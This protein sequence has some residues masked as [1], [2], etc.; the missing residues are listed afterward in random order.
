M[1]CMIYIV[2]LPINETSSEIKCYSVKL[3]LIFLISP[4]RGYLAKGTKPTSSKCMD[5]MIFCGFH[6]CF[7][8]AF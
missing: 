5:E 1:V 8:N 4:S 7:M 2:R 6:I 3:N